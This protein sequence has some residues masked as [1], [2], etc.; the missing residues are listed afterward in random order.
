MTLTALTSALDRLSYRVGDVDE[1]V[2]AGIVDRAAALCERHSTTMGATSQLMW[3]GVLDTILR[4]QLDMDRTSE[5]RA[6]AQRLTRRLVRAMGSSAHGHGG[7][8]SHLP[9][10][11]VLRHVF[12]TCE[13]MRLSDVDDL[14]RDVLRA[15]RLEVGLLKAAQAASSTDTV[16]LLRARQVALA[17]AT[18]VVIPS[19]R[20]GRTERPAARPDATRRLHALAN[21][22]TENDNVLAPLATSI[23]AAAEDAAAA[24]VV[25]RAATKSPSTSRWRPW[26]SSNASKA[27]AT[28]QSPSA[29]AKPSTAAAETAILA[30]RENS[31]VR[32]PGGLPPP[33]VVTVLRTRKLAAR[34]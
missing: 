9:A 8:A 15:G 32:L 3:L 31:R 12:E 23:V 29:P 4:W 19:A 13:D 17:H 6:L 18:A 30:P 26:S 21:L 11:V 10:Q 33:E 25:T 28:S 22:H 7:L 14:I 16:D 34:M 24:A 2:L 20:R 27:P 1:G 5:L